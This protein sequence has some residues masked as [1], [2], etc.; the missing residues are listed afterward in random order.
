MLVTYLNSKIK[1]LLYMAKKPE[2]EI[3][4][5]ICAHN[6]DQILGV[7][8][9][10]AKYASEGKEI[11]TVIFSYGESSHIWLKRKE[12][13]ETRV[14]ESH[15]ADKLLG[16]QESYYLGIKEGNF[17]KKI[18]EKNIEKRIEHII[19]KY[20]PV[21]IFTHAIDD[22][23]P[24]HQ[25]VHR[26]VM[27]VVDRIN[28]K[29]EVYTFP[30]WNPINLIARNKPKLIIDITKTLKK[31]V[32]AFK[33]HKSQKVTILSLFWVV[34]IR[35]FFNGFNNKMKYAEVFYKIR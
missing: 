22:P 21:K 30:V 12:I 3:I 13:V 1:H 31:K 15:R 4:L 35:A 28:K 32:L 10:I 2:R 7:G 18:T 19:R 34:Y 17:L 33:I 26:V 25:A 14:K 29:Y 9:T 5:V 16:I 20:N 24:D 8:G 11:I 6:D 27:T 23:H